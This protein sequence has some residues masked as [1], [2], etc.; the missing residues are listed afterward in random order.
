MNALMIINPVSGKMILSKYFTD[1]SRILA[2]AGYTLDVRLTT[3]KGDAQKIIETCGKDFDTVICCGGDGTLN[4]II[5][6]I[7]TKKININIGYIPCGTTNDFAASI[8]ITTNVI[9][10]TRDIVDGN[11]TSVDVGK[12]SDTYFSYVASFGAFTQSSYNT[13]QN[14]KNTLGHFAYV[15]EGVKEI[16]Y[17]KPTV[18]S[19]TTETGEK[20]SDEY[21]MGAISNSTSIAGIIKL[22][23]K[24]VDMSDGL[25]EVML[26]KFPKNIIDL[27]SIITCVNTGNF[28][29]AFI[30][31]FKAKELVI[32]SDEPFSWALDGELYEGQKTE[33]IKN[34]SKAINI[35]LPLSEKQ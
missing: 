18:V 3:A 19:I 17:L 27:N 10:A 26:I 7:M 25:F 8:G 9:K 15:L 24:I 5:N 34:C 13:P 35:I 11:V 16:P 30:D 6:G 21:F 33:L 31:F 2:D 20:Y 23:E 28:N 14:M 4:E 29:N 22:D 1:I 32:E 12:F